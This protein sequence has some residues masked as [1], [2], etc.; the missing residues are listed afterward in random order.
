MKSM[1]LWTMDWGLGDCQGSVVVCVPPERHS[2]KAELGLGSG[3]LSC[4]LLLPRFAT[5]CR[6]RI[7]FT[8]ERAGL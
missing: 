4:S 1:A 7:Y 2:L 3:Y 6:I 5:K 8:D